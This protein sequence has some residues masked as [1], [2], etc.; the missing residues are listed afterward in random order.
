MIDQIAISFFTIEY[1]ARLFL[2][3]NKRKFF[4]DK[5]NLVDF[6]AIIPFYVALL[7][8]G[9]LTNQKQL[10]TKDIFLR[11]GGPWDHWK[12]RK[13]CSLGQVMLLL[14]N[15]SA[16]NFSVPWL[17]RIMRILRIFKMVRHFVGLQSLVYTLHQVLTNQNQFFSSQP[18]IGLQ[19][20]WTDL[21]NCLCHCPH[22][23]QSCLCIWERK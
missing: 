12:G 6:F 4:F 22:V 1:L 17:V 19:R 5:M 15:W 11:S 10:I 21:D 7:L 20:P 9:H 23:L 3:P 18:I 13:D 2:C 8:E 16:N 14:S